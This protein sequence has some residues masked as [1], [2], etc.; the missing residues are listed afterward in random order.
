MSGNLSAQIS[1]KAP[2]E[3]TEVNYTRTKAEIECL[4]KSYGVQGVRW[5]SFQGQDDVLEF[6]IIATIQG[7]QKTLSIAVS[8]PHIILER[9]KGPIENIDQ[10]YRLLFYWIKSKIEAVMWG[11]ST[12]EQEFLSQIGLALPN[13]EKSTIGAMV[14]NLIVKDQLQSLPYFGIDQRQPTPPSQDTAHRPPCK[15][16]TNL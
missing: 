4:L 10:E 8:P 1:K 14:G 16:V 15:N 7:T 2:Y 6:L 3:D 5:T 9:R 11:L 13:G 12:I